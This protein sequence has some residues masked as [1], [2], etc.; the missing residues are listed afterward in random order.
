VQA[1][2]PDMSVHGERESPLHEASTIRLRAMIWFFVWFFVA[3]VVI[4]LLIL[5]LYYL[6]LADAKKENVPI[7]ALS[8]DV[9]RAVPPEPRL[10]P[11]I[12]HDALPRVDMDQ[13]TARDLADFRARGWVDDKSGAVKIPQQIVDQVVQMSKPTTRG[14]R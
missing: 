6:Y 9:T 13:L 5:A 3:A 8:G 2:S 14:A 10:Q 4:H 12:D 11:S 1:Q 7:T